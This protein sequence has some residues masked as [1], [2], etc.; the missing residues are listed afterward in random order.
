V[1][2][3]PRLDSLGYGTSKLAILSI[4]C[5]VFVGVANKNYI[6]LA[7]LYLY[8]VKPCDTVHCCT[9]NKS[10]GLINPLPRAR[11]AKD[12]GTD[13][14]SHRRV[15][16]AVDHTGN[17]GRERRSGG[18][19]T[20]V[21]GGCSLARLSRRHPLHAAAVTLVGG[22]ALSAP[23]TV[24]LPRICTGVNVHTR[25]AGDGINSGV[26]S[27]PSTSVPSCCENAFLA[28]RGASPQPAP[29]PGQANIKSAQRR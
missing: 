29:D 7:G 15:R 10:S 6:I 13:K 23:R 16:R 4:G 24:E 21:H 12:A 20:A 25:S 5:I 18:L 28:D 1:I 3:L 14:I 8:V 26:P 27:M 17:G 11:P 2:C 9:G 22:T 19:E